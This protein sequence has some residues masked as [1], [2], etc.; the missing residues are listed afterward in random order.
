[1]AALIKGT[2]PRPRVAL[3]G[4][5]DSKTT[6]NLIGLFPTYWMGNSF[7]EI[8]EVVDPKELDLVV[9]GKKVI[10]APTWLN[11]VYVICFS[12]DI[13]YLPAP[14]PRFIIHTPKSASTEAYLLPEL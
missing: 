3:I 7:N 4:E 9:I 5:F 14:T 10:E 8:E 11:Q 1:M 6:Q 12:E 13:N 2:H